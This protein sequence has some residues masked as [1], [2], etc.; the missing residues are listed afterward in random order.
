MRKHEVERT[1][2]T[3]HKHLGVNVVLSRSAD[4][5]MA[6]LKGVTDPETKR[7]IIGEEFIR[8][9]EEEALKIGKVDFLAQGTLY[10][11]VI[12]SASSG[13]LSA[14]KIKSHHNVGGLPDFMSLRLIEPLR[15]LFKDEVRRVG[16]LTAK[17]RAA[18]QYNLK[19]TVQ[20]NVNGTWEVGEIIVMNGL[21]YQVQLAGRRTVWANGRIMRP[22]TAA[23]KPAVKSGVPPKP[24]LTSCAGKI[25]GRYASTGGFGSMTIVFRS[26]KAIMRDAIGDNDVELECWMGGG[27]VYLHNPGESASQDMPLD[28]ND[29][30]TLQSPFGEL[31]RKGNQ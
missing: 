16:P 7:K 5:F 26:G 21:E 1:F 8:V 18:G 6:R 24:G 4:R 23:A 17:D 13:S 28:I 11:D 19:E 15:S 10:P 3:F 20:V 22:A 29:D 9:F 30:G 2:E 12:E 27:R 31:K 14:V 25:E